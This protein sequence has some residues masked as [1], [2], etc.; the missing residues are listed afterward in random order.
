MIGFLVFLNSLVEVLVPWVDLPGEERLQVI[1]KGGGCSRELFIGLPQKLK[2]RAK[3][4][5]LLHTLC[6][7]NSLKAC[8]RAFP[9]RDCHGCL[10]YFKNI[11]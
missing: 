3:G 6:V 1:T 2:H 11:N 10:L 7:I 9:D 5:I 4:I 8:E